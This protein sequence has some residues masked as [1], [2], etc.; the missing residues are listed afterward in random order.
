MEGDGHVGRPGLVSPTGAGHS[1]NLGHLLAR[2][3][4]GHVGVAGGQTQVGGGGGHGSSA[5]AGLARLLR[6]RGGVRDVGLRYG[7]ALDVQ[8]LSQ[9]VQ[10]GEV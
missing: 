9:L 8:S 5:L 1:T 6:R 7:L 4:R 10:S 2:V 3:L